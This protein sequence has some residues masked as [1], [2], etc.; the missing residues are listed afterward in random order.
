MH[1]QPDLLGDGQTTEEVIRALGGRES[2]VLVRGEDAV[3]VEVAEPKAIVL[4]GA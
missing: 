4:Q 3:M 2:P 1:H